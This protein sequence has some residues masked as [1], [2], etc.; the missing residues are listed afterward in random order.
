[1][2]DPHAPAQ[3]QSSGLAIASM[4]LGILSVLTAWIPIIGMIAW[5]LA[6]LGLIFGFISVG[7]P[8]GRGFAIAGLISSGLG[9]LICIAWVTFF[10]AVINEAAKE[11]AFDQPVVSYEAP[12][13]PSATPPASDDAP[14]A[15]QAGQGQTPAPPTN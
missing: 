10:G 1:M 9:L 2:T 4:V 12:A 14:S 11:G 3:P 13:D 6:P 8:V 7:K 5:I 15:D